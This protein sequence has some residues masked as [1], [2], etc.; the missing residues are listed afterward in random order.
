MDSIDDGFPGAVAS[1]DVS[2]ESKPDPNVPEVGNQ[3]NAFADEAAATKALE[4]FAESLKDCD[5]VNE[6]D[7]DGVQ[8]SFTVE[9]DDDTSTSDVDQQF[10]LDF[11][12]TIV[13]QGLQIPVSQRAKFMRIGNVITATYFSS[14]ETSTSSEA[15]DLAELAV[16]KILPV[17]NGGEPGTPD[18]LDL[19]PF[20]GN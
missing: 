6:T 4:D 19:E 20:T 15:E 5:E 11:K 13:S 9:S 12:G 16:A 8:Y 2:I 18:P 17:I 7:G 10:N 14:F 1:K 3:I